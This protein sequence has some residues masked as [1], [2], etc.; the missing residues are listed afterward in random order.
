MQLE[1]SLANPWSIAVMIHWRYQYV[2]AV[3]QVSAK[4][5]AH[6]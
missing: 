3:A 5:A 4:M 6:L 1:A 2:A